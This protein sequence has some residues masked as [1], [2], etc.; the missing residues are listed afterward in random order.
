L[1]P[2]DRIPGI[3][4]WSEAPTRTSTTF[5][6]PMHSLT[7]TDYYAR[8]IYLRRNRQAHPSCQRDVHGS[9]WDPGWASGT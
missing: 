3:S 2:G 4:D 7:T 1:E 8:P 5:A 9:Q 6:T